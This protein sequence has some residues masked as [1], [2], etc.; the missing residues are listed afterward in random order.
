M[1]I[2]HAQRLL[3][4]RST[5]SVQ[6]RGAGPHVAHGR[7]GSPAT[8]CSTTRRSSGATRSRTRPGIHQHGVLEDRETYEI[9]DAVD[10]R[11]GGRADRARQALGPP[12]VRRLAGEDGPARAGR[13]AEP[14]V[15]PLQGAGR[16]QGA[17]SPK[18]T[19][20]RSSPRSSGI[21]IGAPVLDR[22]A[23]SCTA[24]RTRTPTAQRRAGRRRRQGRGRRRGQRHDRRRHRRRS[25]TATGVAGTRA[26]LQGVVGD[27]RWRRARRRRDPA[28]GRRRARRRAAVWP[29]TSS[30]RRP[31]RTSARSTRSCGCASVPT[32]AGHRSRSVTGDRENEPEASSRAL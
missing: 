4:R 15:H 23:S 30:R 20:R 24:A 31:A 29:P 19:S 7:R 25:R 28:R 16:P 8:R 32:T 5:T 1:A 22:R 11:P 12:R 2:A 18:P 9:I 3:R 21:G 13:R 17:R 27:R 10:R 26:R 14:G 6:H